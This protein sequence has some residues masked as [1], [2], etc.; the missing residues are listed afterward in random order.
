MHLCVLELIVDDELRKIIVYSSKG[1][2][3]LI[4][5]ILAISD[6]FTLLR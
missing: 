5:Q 4:L 2:Y 3:Y 6:E 1:I